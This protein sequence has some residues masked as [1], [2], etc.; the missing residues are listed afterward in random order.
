LKKDDPEA[1]GKQCDELEAIGNGLVAAGWYKKTASKSKTRTLAKY[2]LKNQQGVGAKAAESVLEF[3]NSERGKSLLSRIAALGI[4]PSVPKKASAILSGK[5]FVITGTLPTLGRSDASRL[6]VQH[7]GTVSSSVS[8]NTDYL[9]AGEKAGSKLTKAQSLGV[10]VIDEK[11]LR[12][13]LTTDEHAPED[14]SAS[15][16]HENGQLGFF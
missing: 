16:N 1:Y 4:S 9:L 2:T 3:M 8:K 6:I 10:Q 15:S 11:D 13:L 7:G 12:K 14:A 5:S